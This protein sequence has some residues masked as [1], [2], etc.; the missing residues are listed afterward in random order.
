ML[1]PL[2]GD[3]G[4]RTEVHVSDMVMSG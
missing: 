1:D 4:M 3:P 2:S